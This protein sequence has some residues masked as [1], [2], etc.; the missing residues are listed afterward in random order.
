VTS[1]AR[2]TPARVRT[3]R[4]PEPSVLRLCAGT[5]AISSAVAALF[6]LARLLVRSG[7]T[8]ASLLVSLACGVLAMLLI[9]SLGEWGVHR[10]LMHRRSSLPFLR[11]TFD[12]HHRAHHG[13]Q[14]PPDEYV[15]ARPVQYPPVWPSRLDRVCATRAQRAMTVAAHAGFYAVFAGLLAVIPGWLA[16]GN[17]AFTAALVV[18]AAAEISLFIHVHD[19]IHYPG[20]SPFERCAWFR[21]LDR[22]HYMHHVDLR[23]NTNFLLPL[24]DLLFGTLRRELTPDEARRWP[25]YEQART[26]LARPVFTATGERAQPPVC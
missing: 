9:G 4:A 14:F 17:P 20:H 26:R 10:W 18:T 6:L 21:F 1:L 16:T 15:H 25:S 22:H 5:I 8:A 13:V 12:L 11:L 23:A 3:G 24:G 2:P 19:A 7:G